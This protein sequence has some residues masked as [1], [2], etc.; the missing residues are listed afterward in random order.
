MYGQAAHRV[1]AA[2]SVH[3]GGSLYG[4]S[5]QCAGWSIASSVFIALVTLA[6]NFLDLHILMKQV[7][8][9]LLRT[10]TFKLTNH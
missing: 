7:L 9:S 6:V 3:A 10:E 8:N 1:Q 2:H 5:S 4:G